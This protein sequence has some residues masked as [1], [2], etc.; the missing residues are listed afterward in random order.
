MQSHFYQRATSLHARVTQLRFAFWRVEPRRRRL[1]KHT[2][3]ASPPPD[4]QFV[5]SV[6]SGI[7]I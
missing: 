2:A 3:I 4:Q 5:F 1:K 7:N 6:F